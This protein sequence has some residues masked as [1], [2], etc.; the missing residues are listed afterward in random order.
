[1]SYSGLAP[2]RIWEV[3]MIPLMLLASVALFQD[4]PAEPWK[5]GLEARESAL[6]QG[7]PCVLI[8]HVDSAAL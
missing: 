4:A 1:M 3:W 5:T 7:H 6:Q 8:L 2:H